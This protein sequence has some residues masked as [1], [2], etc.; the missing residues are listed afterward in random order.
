[1]A[2][3]VLRGNQTISGA[4]GTVWIDN[5]KIMEIQKLE[6]SVTAN[7]VDIQLGLS[8]DSKII[9][10]KGEGSF[11]IKKVYSRAK[12]IL[13]AWN[14]GQ[15]LRSRIVAKTEDPD[16]PGKQI[17]RV[18]LDNV[19]FNKVDLIKIARGEA[20]EEEYSFGFTPDDASYEECIK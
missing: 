19:W 5:E 3:E 6:S 20:T 15:D 10:L 11:T 8:I 1:M 4:F 2:R 12:K 7:R 16:S 18:S 17:E 13:E 9:S 14:K